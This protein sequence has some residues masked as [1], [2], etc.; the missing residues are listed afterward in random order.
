V[1]PSPR[2]EGASTPPPSGPAPAAVPPANGLTDPAPLALDA[3]PTA[4]S[5]DA[6]GAG[7]GAGATPA[8]APSGPAPAPGARGGGRDAGA[9]VYARA[10]S[11]RLAAERQYPRVAR[12]QRREGTAWLRLVIDAAGGLATPPEVLRS[13]GHLA[14]DHEAVRMALAAAPFPPP[15][16][17]TPPLAIDVPVEFALGGPA[18]E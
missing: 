11:H 5:S 16:P 2:G 9:A 13:A 18:R 4:A 12:L 8:S 1:A 14:L 6:R 15:P 10:V 7:P 17:T 3:D